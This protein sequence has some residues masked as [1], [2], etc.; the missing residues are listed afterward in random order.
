M[1]QF[2]SS[3]WGDE[4]WAAT[5]AVKPI[6]KI[7]TIVSKDTSPPLYYLLLHIWMKIFGT[8]EP[9]IRCLSF[10]FFLAASFFVFLIGKSLWEEE[11]YPFL[12]FLLAFLNPFLFRYGFEGRMYSLLLLTTTSSMYFF[13]KK[14]WTLYIISTLAA[15]YTHHFSIFLVLTQ[16]FWIIKGITRKNFFSSLKPYLI[17]GLGYLPWL[18]PLYYQTSLVQSGFWLSKPTFK[19]VIDLFGNFLLGTEKHFLQKAVFLGILFILFFRKFK[20][21][22]KDLFLLSW[23]IIPITLTFSISLVKSSIFYDRYLLYCVPP[24]ILILVSPRRTFSLTFIFLVIFSLMVIDWHYFTHPTKRPFRELANY[25]KENLKPEYGLINYNDQAH[26]LFESKYYGLNAPIYLP[27]GSLP[28]YTGTA[29]MEEKDIIKILP[30]KEKIMVISSGDPGKI[31]LPGY[32]FEEK[33]DFKNLY[34]L[35]FKKE[36]TNSHCG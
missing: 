4:A 14:K 3:L 9:S 19:S 15:L 20:D 7:I 6:W 31:K 1:T 33:I 24:I 16:L 5:L 32:T 25:V 2:D 8:S 18:Y 12:T 22:G 27:E 26:H 17:I 36:N 21:W 29:L 28:F 35:W 23:A 30:N 11:K 34:L 13:L 10:L